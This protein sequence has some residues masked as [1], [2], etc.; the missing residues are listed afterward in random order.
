MSTH[1]TPPE[2]P[3]EGQAMR[4]RLG[5]RFPAMV[6][7]AMAIALG[8]VRFQVLPAQ[9][10]GEPLAFA[11]ENPMLDARPG[12]RAMF[13]QLEYPANRSCS[14][15]REDGLVL[16]PH[17]GVEGID[18][19]AGLRTGLPYLACDIRNAQPGPDPCGG[20]VTGTVVYALNYFG[21]PANTQV[22]V[23]SIRPRY[24]RWEE[25]DLVVYEVVFERYGSLGG[26]WTT[27]LAREAPVTGLVKWTSL[28]PNQTV[29]IYREVVDAAPDGA[30]TDGAGGG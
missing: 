5:E 17:K 16:R 14:I 20:R 30:G 23:D 22:R 27:Y 8:Y 12:E 9:A 28:L 4:S 19:H 18:E 1:E 26:R 10:Q 29:V 15:V 21:M 3:T 7:A 2:T 24:M 6:R 11:F 13:F 25:R